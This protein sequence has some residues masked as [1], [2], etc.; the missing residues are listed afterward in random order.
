MTFEV[1]IERLFIAVLV[2]GAVGYE[3]ESKRSPAGIR[4]HILVALGAAV[5]SLIS[6]YTLDLS[7]ELASNPLYKDVIKVDMG[8]LGAQVITG[9][10]FIGAG[11]I[12]REKG[13]VRGLTT[14]AT[15]WIVACIGLAVGLGLYQLAISSV[16][17][18]VLTLS[19]LK[20]LE[21]KIKKRK[22]NLLNKIKFEKDEIKFEEDE[23]KYK[24]NIREI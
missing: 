7:L 1:C 9:V 20:T 17:I 5:I 13:S 22:K 6:E 15:L 23:I 14:A 12:I 19:V 11:T 24:D 4:T 3:R 10:G 8:R 21:K 16:V 2:G 18:V